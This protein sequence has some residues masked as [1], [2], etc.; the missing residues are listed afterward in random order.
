MCFICKSTFATIITCFGIMPY[1]LVKGEIN[2]VVGIITNQSAF[3][4]ARC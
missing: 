3:D 1:S 2:G 4:R